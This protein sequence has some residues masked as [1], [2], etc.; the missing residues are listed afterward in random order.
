MQQTDCLNVMQRDWNMTCLHFADNFTASFSFKLKC[1]STFEV[2]IR[3]SCNESSRKWKSA[4]ISMLMYNNQQRLHN[5]QRTHGSLYN[6]SV[7][8]LTNDT[9]PVNEPTFHEMLKSPLT[10]AWFWSFAH[11]IPTYKTACGTFENIAQV[12]PDCCVI[13]RFLSHNVCHLISTRHDFE[14]F[15][16]LP[17]KLSDALWIIKWTSWL[18]LNRHEI[19]PPHHA[20]LT[21]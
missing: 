7:D 20:T 9:M 12:I 18:V 13:T 10:S 16:Q 4:V 11:T 2:C 6:V 8:W 15:S 14:P 19:H 3:I 17:Y 5:N 1:T 21:F